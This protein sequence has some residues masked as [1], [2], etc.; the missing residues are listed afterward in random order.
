MQHVE[1]MGL[2]S[3]TGFQSQLDRAQH[4][5]LV[6]MQNERQDLDH[7]PVAAWALE[8]MTLQLPEGFRH[9]EKGGAIAQGTG[10]ALDHRQIMPPVIDCPSRLVMRAV[11]EP[12]VLAHDLAF[13]HN[14]KTIRVDP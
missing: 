4:S 3:D 10:L 12:D 8:Q 14:D 7:L 9:L 13:G 6:M 2:G 1:N 11:D 5:L